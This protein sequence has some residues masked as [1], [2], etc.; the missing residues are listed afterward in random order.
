V[1]PEKRKAIYVQLQQ[2]MAEDVPVVPIGFQMVIV[3][4]QPQVKGYA[5]GIS[6]EFWLYPLYF[7]E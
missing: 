5:A 3:A 2:Q 1:D 7:E 4:M 6:N